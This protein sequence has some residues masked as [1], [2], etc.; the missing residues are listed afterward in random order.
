[1]GLHSLDSNIRKTGQILLWLVGLLIL[2]REF[3]LWMGLLSLDKRGDSEQGLLSF[4]RMG[5]QFVERELL[6]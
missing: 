5:M 6:R 3:L 4:R 2:E 1:M